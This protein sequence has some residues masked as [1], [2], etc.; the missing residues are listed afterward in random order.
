MN[1]HQH[2]QQIL[3]P[4]LIKVLIK[5]IQQGLFDDLLCHGPYINRIYGDD[6]AIMKEIEARR[7]VING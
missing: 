3:V 1:I 6:K 2:S 5:G 4:V 7:K